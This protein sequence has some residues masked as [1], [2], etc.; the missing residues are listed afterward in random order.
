MRTATTIGLTEKGWIMISDPGVPA[1]KQRR[2]FAAIF[3]NWP[4]GCSQVRFQLNDGRAK[5]RFRDKAALSA[6]AMDRVEKRLA[7]KKEFAERLAKESA[8]KAKAEEEAK[9]A[10]RQAE[11]DKQIAIKP[12]EKPAPHAL[13]QKLSQPKSE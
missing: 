6:A 11:L 9:A 5:V 8:A 13:K 4:Q 1:D 2:D 10:A 3:E 7:E 12:K